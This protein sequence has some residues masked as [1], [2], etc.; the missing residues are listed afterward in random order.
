MLDSLVRVTRRAGLNHFVKISNAHGQAQPPEGAR[1]TFP[2]SYPR[3]DAEAITVAS[4]LPPPAPSPAEH[5]LT[6]T[7]AAAQGTGSRAAHEICHH[8][9]LV[10]FASL[11]AI[12]GTL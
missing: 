2:Q 6:L 3:R 8:I 5:E 11:S 7:Y 12:S 4:N 1:T 10:Q 9:T